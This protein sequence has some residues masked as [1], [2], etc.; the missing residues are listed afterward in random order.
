MDFKLTGQ[1]RVDHSSGVKNLKEHN[2]EILQEITD[3]V[4]GG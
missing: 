4:M 3:Q 1:I 2:V